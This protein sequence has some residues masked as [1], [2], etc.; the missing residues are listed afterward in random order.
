MKNG[1]GREAVRQQ[2]EA[3]D[4]ALALE[5]FNV[6]VLC[7]IGL[8]MYLCAMSEHDEA[9]GVLRGAAE[10]ANKH[11]F[12]LQE[13]QA[14]LG[15]GVLL[16]LAER[17]AESAH[18]Y[19]VS[20]RCAEAGKVPVLAIEAWRMAGQVAAQGG[21]DQVAYESFREAIRVAEGSDA[22]S[23]KDST[24]G[25]AA[26]KLADLCD[27]LHMPEQARCLREQ[28]EAMDTGEI[29]TGEPVLVEA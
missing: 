3:A 21:D 22:A 19:S 26:R 6:A 20:A 27:G 11:G 14:Y 29:G 15:M 17:Y 7:R 16:A 13:A 25:E 8:G 1:E 2:R 12:A 23:V 4:L 28:A 18:A 9:L 5:V 24:A 10:L